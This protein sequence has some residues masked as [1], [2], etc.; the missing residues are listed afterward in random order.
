MNE[1]RVELDAP[2]PGLNGTTNRNGQ[3]PARDTHTPPVPLLRGPRR[4]LYVLLGLF[5]VGLAVLGVVLP[6]L[7]TTPF[8]LLAS[9][10]FVRSSR[11]LHAWLL[12]SRLFGGMLRD[13]D[14][15]RAVRPHVKLTAVTLIPLVITT[16][17]V[18]GNLSWPLVLMLCVLGL[19]G[20]I[21]VLL[22]PVVRDESG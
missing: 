14:K 22:L 3:L 17:A 5:F 19:I 20:L 8:L 1:E 7:P 2:E 6:V 15:H 18:L 10:F 4:L 12:R 11:R 13:W 9:F 21:V 16:S